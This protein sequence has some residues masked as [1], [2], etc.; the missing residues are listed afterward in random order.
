MLLSTRGRSHSY[1]CVARAHQPTPVIISASQEKCTHRYV[2]GE[3][4]KAL[5]RGWRVSLSWD[6]V[7]CSLPSKEATHVALPPPVQRDPLHPVMLACMPGRCVSSSGQ[8]TPRQPVNRYTTFSPCTVFLR[9]YISC[10]KK[11]YVSGC[12]QHFSLRYSLTARA[13]LGSLGPFV[14]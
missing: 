12:A 8:L 10:T 13:C 7:A 4:D 11:T 2:A 9:K 6:F 5:P 14:T 3:S 1:N